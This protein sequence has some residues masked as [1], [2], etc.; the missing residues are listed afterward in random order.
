VEPIIDGTGFAQGETPAVHG[1]ETLR[2]CER[3][4]CLGTC[5]RTLRRNQRGSRD[6]HIL[7]L[8][9]APHSGNC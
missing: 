4:N 8:H 2:L 5:G 6:P 1:G 9:C 7:I 3:R